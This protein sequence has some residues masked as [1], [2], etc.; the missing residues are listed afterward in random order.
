MKIDLHKIPIRDLVK[1]YRNSAEE[2]VTGYGGKLDIRPKY[3]RE[4]VYNAEQRNAVIDTVRQNFPLN[5][6]YWVKNS[7]DSFEVLDGQQRTISICEYVNNNFSIENKYFHTLTHDEQEQ[8]LNYELMVYFC[9]GRDSEKLKWFEIVNIAG[10]VLTKQ[11]LRNAVYTGPWLSDAKKYFSKT[12]CPAAQI[13]YNYLKGTAIRQEY[14]E[15][16]LNWISN[17]NI[18]DYMSDHQHAPDALALWSYFQSV[19]T[20]TQGTFLNY[21]KE[22]KGIDWGFLYNTHKDKPLDSAALEKEISRLMQDDDVTNKKGIYAFVLDGKEKHLNIRAFTDN[23][24]REAY[25][26]QKGICPACNRHFA[27]QEM[28]GDHIDPWHSGGRTRADNC[29]MLCKECNRRKSGI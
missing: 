20:W 12:A 3:Q 27:I 25:E 22:M 7:E 13:A 16:A 24:K 2:G 29:Q 21:R 10:A 1:D 17:G 18:K 9:E 26:R 14:L 8:I 23:M 4:F 6:M 19:I 11:E 15:T 5:V 28:E